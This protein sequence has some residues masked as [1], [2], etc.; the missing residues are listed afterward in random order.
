MLLKT[1]YAFNQKGERALVG[2]KFEAENQI[3]RQQ[4]SS[5]RNH[6]FFGLS[7]ENQPEYSGQEFDDTEHLTKAIMFDIP[8]NMKR[9]MTGELAGG[10][11]PH[12][13]KHVEHKRDC[14]PLYKEYKNKTQ[15][16]ND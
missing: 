8:K 4:L 2:F 1:E 10:L 3:E 13:L 9:Y 6:Y 14:D 5:I 7:E 11:S 16:N 15:E 12:M